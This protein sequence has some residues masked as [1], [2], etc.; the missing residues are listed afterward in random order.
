MLNK[1]DQV[2]NHKVPV[3]VISGYLGAGKTTLLNNILKNKEGL[4]VGVIVNDMGEVN[5]DKELVDQKADLDPDEEEVIELSN[6]CICCQLRGDLLEQA[7]KIVEEKDIDYLVVE[8]SGISEPIPVA[9]TFTYESAEDG[10]RFR[11]SETFDMDTMVSVVDA[12]SFWK[13]YDLGDKL[14][15]EHEH[16]HEHEHEDGD[17]EHNHEGEEHEHD[18]QEDESHHHTEEVEHYEQDHALGEVLVEQIEFCDVL[19]LN[20]I[21]KVPGDVLEE[22]EEVINEL[23]PRAKMIKTTYSD[24]NPEKVLDT[25]LFDFQEIS[26]SAGWKRELLEG[27]SH[28]DAKDAHGVNSFVYESRKPFDPQEL[29]D[30]FEN[31]S[32]DVVRAKGFFWVSTRKD[33]G[34]EFAV[35]GPTTQVMKSQIW[36]DALPE[37]QKKQ[38]FE[39]RPNLKEEIEKH[40]FGDRHNRIV[41]IGTNLNQEQITSELESIQVEETSETK[42]ELLPD[43]RG[44]WTEI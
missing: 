8:S 10:Q 42:E 11:E 39:Q 43:E 40:R 7:E 21:D 5:I 16:D 44:E 24:V 29:R 23:Q 2:N 22:V 31:L 18:E 41:F 15:E 19:V 33:I 30:F 6:G 14:P 4:K 27:H 12:Y 1:D 26:Q 36:V 34:Y 32:N 35:T 38:F 37:Q 13:T 20:K 9:Q 3:T 28:A 17:E 25:G